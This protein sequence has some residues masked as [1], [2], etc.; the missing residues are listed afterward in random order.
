MCRLLKPQPEVKPLTLMATMLCVAITGIYGN[1]VA[2]GLRMHA[3]SD[4]QLVAIQEHLAAINL[5]ALLAESLRCERASSCQILQSLVAVNGVTNPSNAVPGAKVQIASKRW[6][7]MPRGCFD[8]NLVTICRLEQ[9]AI[10]CLD[11]NNNLIL[12]TRVNSYGRESERIGGRFRAYGFF[13]AIVIPNYIRA[14]QTVARNQTMADQ[15]FIACGLERYR[16][17]NGR[18]L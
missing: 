12:V 7:G 11:L 14:F 16:V 17:A 4:P 3:W 9:S 10:D 5:P 15:A 1:V 18:H 2:D 13:A 6:R 8:Q